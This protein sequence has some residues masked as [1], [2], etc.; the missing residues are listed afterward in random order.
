M[1]KLLL[2]FG[3]ISGGLILGYLLQHLSRKGMIFSPQVIPSLRKTLQKIAL[4]VLFPVAFMAVIWV[5]SLSDARLFILPFIGLTALISGGVFGLIGAKLLKVNRNQTGVL[6]CCGSFTNIGAI[7]GLVCYVYLGEPGFALVAMYKM[8]EEM[9]YYTVGFPIARFCSQND[10]EQKNFGKRL[11]GVI[12]D[13]FV[14]TALSAFALGAI[15]NLTGVPR[16]DFF[17]T[18]SSISV[19]L[20]T[21]ALLV[22][23]GLGMQFSSMSKY[24]KESALITGTKFLLV[25]F[26]ACSF[27]YLAGLGNIMDGLPLKVVCIVSSMPVAFNALVAAS[28]YDM[29]LDLA[30]S[31]WL[32][33]TLSLIAVLPWLYFVIN[34]IL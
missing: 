17:E 11:L 10:S 19:P 22:S 16:P 14:Y 29:D 21:L 31:C 20:G 9:Y 2:T 7:G 34:N 8:F 27:A 23:I 24:I 30:N 32:M 5:V 4:L 12:A 6:Y 13:P 18:L 26:I 25:P 3:L 1:E 15:L 28:I 33:T